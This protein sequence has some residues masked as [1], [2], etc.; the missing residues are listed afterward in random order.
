[1]DNSSA[2]ANGRTVNIQQ[3]YMDQCP[4]ILEHAAATPE[5]GRI[6][7]EIQLYRIA[8]KLQ[9][10]QHRLQ[11]AEAEYEEIER[12]KMEWAHLLSKSSL[13]DTIPKP[14]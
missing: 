1:M 11:F 5:D 7:A 3:Q 14:S 12:W 9:H 13:S 2:L 10:S 4:R 8:L 6:V